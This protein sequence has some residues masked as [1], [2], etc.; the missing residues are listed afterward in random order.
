MNQCA[1]A[2]PYTDG[3]GQLIHRVV[4]GN[5]LTRAEAERARDE[6]RATYGYGAFV[7]KLW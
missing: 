7:R 2:L 3:E 1:H 5:Y 4:M 6:I